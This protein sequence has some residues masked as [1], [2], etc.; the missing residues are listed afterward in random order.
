MYTYISLLKNI[1]VPS[2]AL[3]FGGILR[4]NVEGSQTPPGVLINRNWEHKRETVLCIWGK[5]GVQ[6]SSLSQ[7]KRDVGGKLQGLAWCS[8]ARLIEF[9][10]ITARLNPVYL[11]S[12]F[13]LHPLRKSNHRQ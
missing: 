5:E 2:E 7:E 11:I 4:P 12:E 8:P 1:T 6:A 13:S 10:I 3:S 9:S